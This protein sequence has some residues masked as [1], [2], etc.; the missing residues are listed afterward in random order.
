MAEMVKVR[1]LKAFP[2]NGVI[3]RPGEIQVPKD[4]VARLVEMK[5][6]ESPDG[7]ASDSPSQDAQIE[8][9]AARIGEGLSIERSSG[10]TVA[11]YLQRIA[12]AMS[13]SAGDELPEGFPARDRLIAQGYT[14]RT[15]VREA[16]DEELI[17]LDGI[18]EGRVAQIR[19]ALK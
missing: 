15:R 9:A 6:I 7:T 10:E 16:S 11:D 8:A 18:A 14:T 1:A 4:K 17:A 13:G 19:E 5:L 12:D 2:L 3:Q